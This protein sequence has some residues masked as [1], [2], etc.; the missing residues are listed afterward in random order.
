MSEITLTEARDFFDNSFADWI[1]DL[2]ITIT[3]ITKD[4]ATMRIP[5]TDRINRL[6]GMICGQAIMALADTA[7][8]FAVAANAGSFVSMTSV[9]MQTTFL[10]PAEGEELYAVAQIVKSGKRLVYGDVNLH[11][12]D[13]AKPV[14]HVTTSVML[15]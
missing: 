7:M 6:G 4:S 14:A 2:D 5:A 8:V 9:N 3:D 11:M 1:K 13:A 15:L 12:G 10:R